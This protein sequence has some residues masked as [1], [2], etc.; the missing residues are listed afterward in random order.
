MA[1]S[2]NSL[3]STVSSYGTR[4]TNLE[5]KVV[6]SGYSETLLWSGE[7]W[8]SGATITLSQSYKNFDAIIIIA[9]ADGLV[10]VK[11]FPV[12]NISLNT[13]YNHAYKDY[14][15]LKFPSVKSINFPDQG[16]IAITK[17]YGVKFSKVI[18]YYFSNIINLKILLRNIL[19][20]CN[21]LIRHLSTPSE[22]NKGM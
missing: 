22:L 2:L 11:W 8:N 6:K 13:L 3:N 10:D 12:S 1:I 17:V 15:S 4:I 7:N 5:N 18:L 21:Y 14:G 9:K 20:M 16:D 19:M